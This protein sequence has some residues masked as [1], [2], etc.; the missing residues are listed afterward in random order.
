VLQTTD[1][2][3]RFH[4]LAVDHA[5]LTRRLL[6]RLLKPRQRPLVQEQIEGYNAASL[7]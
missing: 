7:L 2:L 1:D 4:R 5:A 3:D 6:G